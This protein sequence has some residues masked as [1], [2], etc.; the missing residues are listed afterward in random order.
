MNRAS[1]RS[2]ASVAFADGASGPRRST[3]SVAFADEAS[4]PR[5]SAASVAFA[6]EASGPRRSMKQR[7]M[8]QVSFIRHHSDASQPSMPATN[9]Q[10]RQGQSLKAATDEPPSVELREVVKSSKV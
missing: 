2:T 5:P 8:K 6:D 3:A 9:A 10:L 1:R 7:S 4:G